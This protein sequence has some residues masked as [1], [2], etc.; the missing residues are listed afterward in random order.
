MSK[1]HFS[2]Q[3]YQLTGHYL[4]VELEIMSPRKEI[5]LS[6]PVWSPGSY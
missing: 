1:L 2:I 5:T 4:Q 3:E 6:L